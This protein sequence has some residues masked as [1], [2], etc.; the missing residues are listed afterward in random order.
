M[1]I[2]HIHAAWTCSIDMTWA[3]S[4][5]MDISMTMQHGSLA[6]NFCMEHGH[7]SWTWWCHMDMQHGYAAWAC[8]KDMQFGHRHA[9]WMWSKNMHHWDLCTGRLIPVNNGAGYI[10]AP[11]G[12]STLHV[13]PWGETRKNFII[14]LGKPADF[15][16]LQS[17][18]KALQTL[19]NQWVKSY[20][21]K[22]G[23]GTGSLL[24][25]FTN[26]Y[27]N[28]SFLGQY[29]CSQGG[30]CKLFKI[31]S[32]SATSFQGNPSVSTIFGPP[33]YSLDNTFN[34]KNLTTT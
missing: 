29:W 7:G 4:M 10:V 26:S 23:G 33:Q 30:G 32:S 15:S 3:C 5:D 19:Q 21:K 11:L 2:Q 6:R 25:R 13:E 28:S 14:S 8:C 22:R 34:V 16:L 20:I 12:E 31:K 1:I 17:Q 27:H 24:L 9:A 18:S